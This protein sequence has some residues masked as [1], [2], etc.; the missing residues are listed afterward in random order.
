MRVS[1][2]SALVIAAVQPALADKPPA[3]PD[4]PGARAH[5]S[6]PLYKSIWRRDDKGDIVHLQSGLACDARVGD[7]AR[8]DIRAYKSSGLDV[9]CNY[10]DAQKNFIT[11]YLT[12]RAG[13]TL[14]DDMAEAKR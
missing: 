1:I 10:L 12:R 2:L 8:V 5:A 9:S 7:F 13:Q 4:A 14:A 3:E 11:M 6:Q